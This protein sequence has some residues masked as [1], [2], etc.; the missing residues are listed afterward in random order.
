MPEQEI[1][2]EWIVRLIWSTGANHPTAAF[3]VGLYVDEK[4]IAK[5]SGEN[6][7]VAEEMAARDGLRR[8]FGTDEG[9]APLPF[10]D[11]AR[12]LSKDINSLY[13]SIIKKENI[14]V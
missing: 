6:L 14:S 12:K 4:M 8:L 2:S 5:G 9:A 3:I 11:R 1:K 10:G 7:D 13:E